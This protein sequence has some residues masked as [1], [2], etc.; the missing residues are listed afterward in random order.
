MINASKLMMFWLLLWAM[1][2]TYQQSEGALSLPASLTALIQSNSTPI[3]DK[4]YRMT[5]NVQPQNARI[6]VM[7]I[8]QK[9]INGMAL[10]PG[11]YQ[12]KIDARKYRTRTLVVNLTRKSRSLNINLEK[13]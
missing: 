13:L 5:I 12:V 1:L 11:K 4:K 6:R 2:I 7:N 10:Q 3:L 8:K 9:F